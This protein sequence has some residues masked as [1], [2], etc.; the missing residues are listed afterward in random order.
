MH[1]LGGL[2]LGM[3]FLYFVSPS[4]EI[5]DHK[6]LI[7][8]L[9]VVGFAVFVGVLWEFFEFLFDVFVVRGGHLPP[10]QQGLA[11]TMKDLFFDLFGGFVA[12]VAYR[13]QLKK[14]LV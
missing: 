5:K 2:W 3:I 6:F 4:L 11:D 14:N 13:F 9:L 1:F 8:M 10:A 7:E 12:F